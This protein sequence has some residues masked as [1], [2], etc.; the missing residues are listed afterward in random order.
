SD[1]TDVVEGTRRRINATGMGEGLH[2]YKIKDQYYIVSAIPGAHTDMVVARSSSLDG[3]WQVERMVTSESLGVPTQRSLRSSGFA[4]ART[5]TAVANDPNSGGGL[6]LHQG[7]IVDTPSGEWWSIIMQDHG[8][9][10]RLVA[11]VPVTW[12]R[13]FP[14]IGLAGNLRKAPNTWI[15][16]NT[17]Y[18][19][20]PKPLFVRNDSFDSPKLNPVW[21]WNHVTDDSKWSLTEKAGVLRLHSLAAESFWTARNTLTQRPI[22][23]ESTATVELDAAGLESGDN[24]GLALLNAP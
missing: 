4:P 3:P 2:F 6:T 9:V 14:I 18:A 17:G 1:L 5:F 15:K 16:P 21:Q 10:G 19:Q 13:D 23:P 8:S 24:A 11:L 7:G 12:D 20:D 22:G